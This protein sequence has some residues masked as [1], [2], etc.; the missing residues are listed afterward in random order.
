[1]SIARFDEEL[2]NLLRY[3]KQYG[4]PKEVLVRSLALEIATI[5]VN[6]K[7]WDPPDPSSDFFWDDYVP[8]KP[9]GE[10]VDFKKKR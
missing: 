6:P 10:V 4:I 7:R 5:I 3:A 2:L 1:M 9:P 8:P